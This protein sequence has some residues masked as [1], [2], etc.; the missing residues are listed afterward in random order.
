MTERKRGNNGEALQFLKWLRPTGP[1]VL[2]SISPDRRGVTT[3][4]FTDQTVDD[5]MAWLGQRNGVDNCYVMVNPPRQHLDKKA[6]KEDVE[7]LAYLHV[8]CDPP[9]G[10]DLD[11]SRAEILA[12]LQAF[13]P[14]PH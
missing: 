3:K 12:R 2:T 8:D 1:W 6:S 11:S 9:K 4:T 5:L 13:A 10:A 7:A 14:K